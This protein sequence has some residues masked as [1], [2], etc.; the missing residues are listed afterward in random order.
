MGSNKY[1]VFYLKIPQENYEC[2]NG[3]SVMPLL[4]L[5]AGACCCCCS[6]PAHTAAVVLGRPPVCSCC[7]W[8]CLLCSC[9]VLVQ[10]QQ[11]DNEAMGAGGGHWWS[12]EGAVEVLTA[13]WLHLDATGFSLGVD[14][15]AA[16]FAAA[17]RR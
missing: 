17:P 8:C 9:A 13:A 10:L 14:L 16:A 2:Q 12:A 4:L 15:G 1:E 11:K 3:R 7:C 5:L 6:W